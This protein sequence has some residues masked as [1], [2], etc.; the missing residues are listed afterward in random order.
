MKPKWKTLFRII[1]GATG[2]CETVLGLSI[3][4]FASA[5][6][7]FIATGVLYEPLNLRILGMMDFYIGLAYVFLAVWPDKYPVLNR[8]T[9]FL[10]FGLSCLFFVEGFWLL[11]EE[12]LRTTYQLLSAFDF[13][14]FFI[15]FLYIRAT[16]TETGQ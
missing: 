10:R 9:C 1:I 3:V 6:Q 8:G 16:L 13:F 5:L 4:F 2:I 12:G 11:K 7:S 15:Q 14:L